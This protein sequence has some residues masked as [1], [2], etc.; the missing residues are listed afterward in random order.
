MNPQFSPLEDTQRRTS[1]S[2]AY[3]VPIATGAAQVILQPLIQDIWVTLHNETPSATAGFKLTAGTMTA[4]DITRDTV[5]K[6]IEASASAELR[7]QSFGATHY[8]SYP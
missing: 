6:V 2:A 4:F 7:Y 8:A 5:I 1:L 3:T